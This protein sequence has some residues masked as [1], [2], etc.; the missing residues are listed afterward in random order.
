MPSI[1]KKKVN[2]ITLRKYLLVTGE[3]QGQA[4]KFHQL[5]W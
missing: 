4:M 3:H 5:A 2:R 1:P